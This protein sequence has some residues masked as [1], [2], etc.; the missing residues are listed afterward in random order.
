MT[1]GAELSADP[2]IPSS[3]G[4]IA[5]TSAR[6]AELY[7]GS[8]P[9]AE[10]LAYLLT[11]NVDDARDLAQEAFVRCVG[12]FRHLRVP[13]AFHAY[14]RRSVVN[15]HMSGLR[16]TRVERAYLARAGADD[17]R[18]RDPE[19]EVREELWR[20]LATL[21]GR[22]R[23]ALVLRYYE[24]LSERDAAGVLGCTV[25]ALKMLV[26]RGTASLRARLGEHD[27]GEAG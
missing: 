17:A 9:A 15:L 8:M 7:A 2:D 13:D 18:T 11:G 24:D 25:P 27:E 19:V 1:P 23:A 14:L 26:A 22:Q 12:R 4:V 10:R 21:P 20:A 3:D 16:R 6:L 5:P